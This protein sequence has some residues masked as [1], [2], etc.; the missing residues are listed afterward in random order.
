MLT[1]F[2]QKTI[3]MVLP[4]I[5]VIC[6]ISLRVPFVLDSMGNIKA[7]KGNA[8]H[9][10]RETRSKYNEKCSSYIRDGNRTALR[11]GEIFLSHL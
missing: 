9:P 4:M 6:M 3:P 10:I 5:F 8:G 7:R 1:F 11:E 2:S